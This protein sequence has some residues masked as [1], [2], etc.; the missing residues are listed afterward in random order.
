[1]SAS[2]SVD[3]ESAR[4][5]VALVSVIAGV[6]VVVSSVL[7]DAARY[8]DGTFIASSA[9][10]VAIGVER[11]SLMRLSAVAD[12][13][14]T[15][16]LFLPAAVFL[17]RLCRPRGGILVDAATAAGLVY[18]AL[19]VCGAA[20]LA[21]GSEPLIRRYAGASGL[22]ASQIA[23]SFA[24]LTYI[25]AGIFQFGAALAGGI[26]WLGIGLA[27]RQR[28]AAL[29][30]Y[31]MLLGGLAILAAMG[32]TLGLQYEGG[33]PATLAFMPLAV[34]PAWVGVYLWR[35]SPELS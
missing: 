10:F 1:M 28:T 25:A 11:A 17:W 20:I 8:R 15:Y 5:P 34:W 18:V 13:L 22:E 32:R 14:G 29:G 35:S 23:L 24:V 3:E 16:L 33:G 26:W 2:L 9:D 30:L 12:L 4:Q 7:A 31:S 21:G 19:G 6:L 27:L